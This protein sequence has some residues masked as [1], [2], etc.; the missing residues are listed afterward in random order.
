M[1]YKSTVMDLSIAVWAFHHEEKNKEKKTQKI[2][3]E[4]NTHNKASW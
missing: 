3:I 2:K 1:K 4:R